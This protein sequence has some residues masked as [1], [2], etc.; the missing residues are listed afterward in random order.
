LKQVGFSDVASVRG[1]T[2]AW[3]ADGRALVADEVHLEEPRFTETEWTHA[4]AASY[5]I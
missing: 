5:S 2:I 3:Q 1:G 4:G